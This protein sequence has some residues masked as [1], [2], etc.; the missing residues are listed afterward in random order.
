MSPILAA[1]IL[2]STGA[3][4]LPVPPNLPDLPP[5]SETRTRQPEPPEL[6]SSGTRPV[7]LNVYRVT[8]CRSDLGA[9]DVETPADCLEVSAG[10]G[11]EPGDRFEGV[12]DGQPI[13]VYV[14]S[15]RANPHR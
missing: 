10:W 9:F 6:P 15:T 4:P 1:M 8:P 2:N 12:C 13:R 5:K 11:W 3:E 14:E 7:F